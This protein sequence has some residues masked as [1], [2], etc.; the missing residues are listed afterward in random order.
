MA[1]DFIISID[2]GTTGSRVFCFD[3]TGK[4]VSSAY[5][6][7]TQHFPKPGWVEHD[8][9][10]IWTGVCSLLA[11]ALSKGGLDA[12]NAAGIAITNQRET[13][14]IW[15]KKTGEPVHRAIVWQCRRT[16]D[17]CE[18]L[19]K[20]NLADLVRKKTG[21]VIDAYFSGTKI[22]WMLENVAGARTRA[23]KGE[24]MA[25][26]IDTW[27][28][29]KLTGEWKTD[30]TN[31]SRTL[32]YNIE[33]KQWDDE[34]CKILNVPRSL[35]PEVQ[36]SRSKFGT[37]RNV[38]GL[39]D[40]IPVLAIAGDQ[41]AA[42][43]GQLCVKPGQAKNTY[44]TGCFLLF[45]TGSKYIISKSGL[46][47]TLACDEKGG[48]S[49]ALEGSVFIGGAVIQWLRDFMKFFASARET[50]DM[51]KNI[52]DDEDDVVFVPAFA[53]LGAPHWDMQ[54]RG[55]VFGLTRDTDPARMTRAALKSIAF[56]SHDLVRAMEKDTGEK[57]PSLR[58]DGGATANHYL[59][60]F[61]SDILNVPV[62]RPQNAD[63]TALGVAYL[64]G[65]EAGI[66]KDAEA[67]LKLQEN[68]TFFRPSMSQERRDRELRLWSK[69][70][71]RVKNWSE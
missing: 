21:L 67:L 18:E 22:R 60:Q 40:G 43:F 19:K 1:K 15:D 8:A 30:Y 34:L 46:L 2:Q 9:T 28:L 32:L 62:E 48:V 68:R 27:L 4:V 70:V 12:R 55:A 49:Y 23:E 17:Y 13:T 33:T 11:E 16:A 6:E 45:Q 56:Q 71:E 50:E 44:G 25:G 31:A 53:G 69:G 14:L 24:L 39:I 38:Q 57:L 26:T 58:V 42:L 3:T 29:Y 63:T 65:M 47:T 61:Q 52:R 37:T 35:L 20:K 54:A 64:A 59:M 7:F 41:Q 10:E 66:W 5:R 36:A 51:I